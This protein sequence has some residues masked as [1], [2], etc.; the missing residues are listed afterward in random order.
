MTPTQIN[1]LAWLQWFCRVLS[2]C[3]V[4]AGAVN[5]GF[6]GVWMALPFAA[7]LLWDCWT[8]RRSKHV[9]AICQLVFLLAATVFSTLDRSGWS[10]FYPM[11]GQQVEVQANT[12]MYHSKYF[13]LTLTGYSTKEISD[14]VVEIG[15]E[16]H[17]DFIMPKGTKLAVQKQYVSGHPE[18]GT[19]YVFAVTLDNVALNKQLVDAANHIPVRWDALDLEYK[20]FPQDV[21]YMDSYELGKFQSNKTSGVMPRLDLL[22]ILLIYPIHFPLMLI[23]MWAWRRLSGG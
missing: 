21:L 15:V 2:A 4:V 9:W 23:V 1:R 3:Y 7:Y 20:A 22:T 19:S 14:G 13:P 11:V 12:P 16:K 5:D 8:L 6:S 10:W 18:F 17:P